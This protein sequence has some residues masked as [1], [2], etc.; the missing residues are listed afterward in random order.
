MLRLTTDRTRCRRSRPLGWRRF[1]A[2]Y[3]NR[4]LVLL[5]VAI[6]FSGCGGNSS[7]GSEPSPSLSGN[8]QF[9][10]APPADGSFFGGLEGGFLLESSGSV[11][12]AAAYAVSLSKLL[13]PCSSGS[14]AISGTTTGQ[15]VSLTAVAGTQTFTFSGMLS[16]DG[17]TMA[18]TYASTAGTA[19]D[20]AP[21]GT[22][23]T[24]LQ[25]SA[26]VVPPISGTI[27]GSFHST[28]GTAGLSNQDFPVTG[29]LTQE[30][31]TG[32]STA[33]VTGT[34]SFTNP[35][36]SASD[37]P[38]F[39]TA[40]VYG[41]I[42]GNSVTLQIVGSDESILGQIGEPAGSNG[43]TGLNAATFV[44]LHGG[45]VL[46]GVGPSYLVASSACPGTLDSIFTDGVVST[47]DYGNICLAIGA[48]LGAPNACQEPIT[49]TPAA[50]SFPAA[51]VGTSSTETITLGNTS[52]AALNG[53]AL[54]FANIPATAANFTETDVCGPGGVAS[55][56]EP[57]ELASGES[58]AITVTFTAQC[59]AECGSPLQ[60]TLT[61][62]SPVSADNDTVFTV[63]I[64]GSVTSGGA[65]EFGAEAGS[66]ASR[67]PSLSFAKR[68]EHAIEP[69]PI[70][71]RR[72]SE[73]MEHHA[74]F[75]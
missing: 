75:D 40:S 73:D 3:L 66:K 60:A 19:G 65:V 27:Q 39:D 37:Y 12:G 55:E 22:A 24:G 67:S 26:I 31:N 23:Q 4:L 7:A 34:L 11:T 32:A 63:P 44:S 46:N 6:M 21:C 14:A 59:A 25:W 68:N 38:C 42:S 8:W 48:P 15:T 62:T 71:S 52:G 47:G 30:N 74:D 1:L 41:G 2:P 36:T 72:T 17:S 57:F 5:S 64:T 58:C 13:I 56:G 69:L 43:A 50:L 10:V 29:S 16:L 51:A 70:S 35:A 9:T 54:T 28:G 20:G 18:G 61:V 45:Y 33:V 49:L 53:L